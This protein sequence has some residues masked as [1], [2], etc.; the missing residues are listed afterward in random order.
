MN[1][2]VMYNRWSIHSPRE[3]STYDND[4]P[5]GP[6]RNDAGLVEAAEPADRGD[7]DLGC[8][9]E[10]GGTNSQPVRRVVSRSSIVVCVD[11]SSKEI[12][13]VIVVDNLR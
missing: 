8:K 7:D 11:I 9:Q 2:V 12:R 10:D 5:L 4:S 1:S 13:V 6:G 3:G